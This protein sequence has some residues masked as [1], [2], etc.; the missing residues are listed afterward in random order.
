MRNRIPSVDKVRASRDGHEYHEAWTARRALELLKP[1]STLSAIAVEGLSPAD[2]PNASTE[3]VEIADLTLYYG[4]PTFNEAERTT[5]AQFKYSVADGNTDFRV[6]HAK[7]T[8]AKFAKTYRDY[9]KKYGSR[10]VKAKLDF[11]LVTNRPIFRA[12][13]QAI[14]A[15]ARGGTATS[16]AKNQADQLRVASGLSGT[17]L[18]EFAGKL[19]LIGVSGSLPAAKHEL[20]SVIVDWSATNDPI[21][22]ARLGQLRQMV[23]DKAGHV[24]TGQN[25][26]TRPDILAALDIDDADD[27]LPCRP[28]LPEI[29]KVIERNQLASTSDLIPNLSMP[30]LIHAAGGVGKTVF[31]NSLASILREHSEV[32]FF[33]CFGGG[34]YRSPEDA[35]HQPRKGLIHIVNTLAFRGL[36]DP[37]LPQAPNVD[38]LLKTFRRRLV[39]CVSTLNRVTPGRTLVLFIDA[40]DNAELFARERHEDSFP[41]CLLESLHYESIVGVKLIVSCRSERKPST[42]ARYKELELK[43]FSDA[44]T[45]AFLRTRLKQVSAA[46]IRVAQA[47]SGGNPRVLDY[48]VK[49]G[50]GL[51]DESEI[52]KP[53]VLDDL[54]QKRISDALATAIERGY[55]QEDINV[56]LAGLSVLPPPVPLDEY[57]GANGMQLQEIESF[58]ADLS[59][60]LER[61]GQGLMFRDEPTE[62]LIRSRYAAIPEALSRVAENL[63]ARQDTSVYAA[64]ALPGLLNQLGDGEQ[65]FKLAFDDRIPAA[66]SSTVGKR[67]IRYARIKAAV[68]HSAVKRDHNHLVELLTELSTLAAVDQRGASYLLRNPDLVVAAQD[69]DATRRL[70]ET[71][72]SWPGARHARMA[73]ANTLLGESG[74]ATRHAIAAEEYVPNRPHISGSGRFEERRRAK[75]FFWPCKGSPRDC[76]V[77]SR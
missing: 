3:T 49:S 9:E 24:G 28:A 7:N 26:I 17:D 15:L 75:S 44:E 33:D 42:N 23:R 54:I 45:T 16:E 22:R 71:R 73:I 27:L 57:A 40:I 60:L 37:I 46:E 76:P 63:L 56:F 51:L 10:A 47:R 19:R 39:Q 25:L 5:I 61:T 48:L 14:E 43:P 18:A 1:D 35:R 77:H 20:A 32:V 36:C 62:T 50:H 2:Q 55:A 58:A 34:A 64:R 4:H 13:Q 29:G 6:S 53:L 8:V 30:L 31:L 12:L 69:A 11:S 21:A 41:T 74:E 66:I 59:P 65:L 52:N 67:N 68:L 38:S 70:F 72:T